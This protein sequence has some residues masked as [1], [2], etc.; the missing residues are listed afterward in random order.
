MKSISVE[1]VKEKLDAIFE[2]LLNNGLRDVE[3]GANMYWAISDK[4]KYDLDSTPSLEVGDLAFDVDLIGKI[5]TPLALELLY[6]SEV[7]RAVAFEG[8]RRNL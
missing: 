5:G 3:I 1:V 4:E 2:H 8:S 6:F 7:L